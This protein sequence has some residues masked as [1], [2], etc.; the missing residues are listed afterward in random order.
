M[1]FA[2]SLYPYIFLYEGNC[3]TLPEMT[4]TTNKKGKN[5][6]EKI[7]KTRRC[8]IEKT[9]CGTHDPPALFDLRDEG[10]DADNRKF[11]QP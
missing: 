3:P 11:T 7:E 5:R 2:L 8:D 1:L 4:S 6:D 10:I 9:F